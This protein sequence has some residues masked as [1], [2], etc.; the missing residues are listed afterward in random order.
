MS[1][2]ATTTII[3]NLTDDPDFRRTPAG[4]VTHFTVASNPRIQDRTTGEWRDGDTLFM[5]CSVWRVPAEHIAASL[6]RGARVIVTGRLRQRSFETSSG[7][8]RTVVELDAD[9]VGASLRFTSAKLISAGTAQTNGAA[10]TV[11]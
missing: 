6:H 4:D 2:E 7:E 1:G 3:G 11:Q 5:P 8:K 10:A 9:E